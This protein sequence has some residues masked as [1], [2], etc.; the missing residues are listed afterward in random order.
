MATV[1]FDN[2]ATTQLRD[3]VVERMT[4][5]LKINFGN[6]SSTHSYGRQSKSI[7]ET[8]RKSIA[9]YFNVSA[10]EIVFTSGATESNNIAVK[11]IARFYGKR[12]KH[13]IVSYTFLD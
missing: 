11:G 8:C 2:A 9:S 5:C 4:E 10:S 13:V 6:P 7:I 12:K 3:E 1:Y